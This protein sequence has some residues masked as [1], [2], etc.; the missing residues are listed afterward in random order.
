M[1]KI[2]KVLKEIAN[3]EK[4]FSRNRFK[5]SNHFDAQEKITREFHKLNAKILEAINKL[6]FIN[7]YPEEK[8]LVVILI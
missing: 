8:L 6:M 7:F 2:T 3:E 5:V 1:I 4:K